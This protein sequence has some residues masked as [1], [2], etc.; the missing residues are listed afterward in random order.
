MVSALNPKYCLTASSATAIISAASHLY[1]LQDVQMFARALCYAQ[2]SKFISA[3]I[4]C[5]S[6]HGS[7]VKH[8]SAMVILLTCILKVTYYH[9]RLHH[10]I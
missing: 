8:M 3:I 4:G 7:K 1:A 10:S 5:Q 6:S 2:L 9:S